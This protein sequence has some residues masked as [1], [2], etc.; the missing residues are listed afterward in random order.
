MTGIEGTRKEGKING[1]KQ[2]DTKERQ[3]LRKGLK[4][5]QKQGKWKERK[6]KMDRKEGKRNVRIRGSEQVNVK[7]GRME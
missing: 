5:S 7:E 2:K 4:E 6:E 3:I 1:T